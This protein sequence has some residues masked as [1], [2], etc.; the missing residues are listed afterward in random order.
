MPDSLPADG[1]IDDGSVKRFKRE[2]EDDVFAKVRSSRGGG[3]VS[4]SELRDEWQRL[5]LPTRGSVHAEGA[6]SAALAAGAEVPDVPPLYLGA[7]CGSEAAQQLLTRELT[8]TIAKA[9]WHELWVLLGQITAC[10]QLL[11]RSDAVRPWWVRQVP[12]AG[13][14]TEVAERVDVAARELPGGIDEPISVE[15]ATSSSAVVKPEVGDGLVYAQRMLDA[16]QSTGSGQA[17]DD[18]ADAL[19]SLEAVTLATSIPH[20]VQMF[21][22]DDGGVLARIVHRLLPRLDPA[23]LAQHADALS[24]M[25]NCGKEN[26]ER[27]ALEA[28]ALLPQPVLQV[29]AD[30]VCAK[31]GSGMGFVPRAA[32]MTLGKLDPAWLAASGHISTELKS[33]LKDGDCGA[34]VERELRNDTRG[35]RVLDALKVP[36][37]IE[38]ETLNDIDNPNTNFLNCIHREVCVCVMME[39]AP[40]EEQALLVMAM[41]SIAEAALAAGHEE[42]YFVARAATQVATRVR[43][44]AKLGEASAVPQL[45]ILDLNIRVE[46]GGP[47]FYVCEGGVDEESI[48]AFVIKYMTGDLERVMLYGFLKK[49]QR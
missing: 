14:G 35:S 24:Q 47:G 17:R 36:C 9:D 40:F 44:I 1:T 11:P 30:E 21:D 34:F 48:A 19:S 10:I 20:M 32:A 37:K 33:Y 45:V 6:E 4:V 3:S 18:A 8:T 7:C 31:L 2:Y 15:T 26:G 5:L 39:G 43:K 46:A 27:Y 41:R 12:Q 25:I 16:M 28:M 49:P 29:Y 23:T 13:G 38:N 22:S 42:S